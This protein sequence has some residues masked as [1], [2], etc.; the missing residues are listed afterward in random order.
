MLLGV[1]AALLVLWKF[2]L[3]SSSRCPYYPGPTEG[4][5]LKGVKTST[6]F[7]GKYNNKLEF[8]VWTEGSNQNTFYGKAVDIL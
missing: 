4:H 7:K 2:I 8:L 5:N 1:P 6:M 3:C